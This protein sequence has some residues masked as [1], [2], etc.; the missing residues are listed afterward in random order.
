MAQSSGNG[1]RAQRHARLA[2]RLVGK[3]VQAAAVNF[4]SATRWFRNAE[5]TGIPVRPEFF[6]LAA[7]PRL[8]F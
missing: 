7:P 8:T 5:V 2:N 6:T 4:P 1:L 3:R